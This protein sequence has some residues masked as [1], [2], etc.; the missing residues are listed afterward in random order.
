[1]FD[2][3]DIEKRMKGALDNLQA[4]S[5]W[6]THWQGFCSALVDNLRVEVYGSQMPLNQLA[7]SERS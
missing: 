3:N 7:S 6:P 4:Q 5:C 2:M 1:M